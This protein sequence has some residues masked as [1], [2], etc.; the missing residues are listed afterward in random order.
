MA[1]STNGINIK[2]PEQNSTECHN[3]D[4]HAH[5]DNALSRVYFRYWTIITHNELP[6][7]RLHRSQ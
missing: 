5:S 7:E 6:C 2:A 4:L 3:C 1:E